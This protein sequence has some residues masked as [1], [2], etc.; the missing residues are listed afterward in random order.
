LAFGHRGVSSHR[1]LVGT[2]ESDAAVA[3]LLVDL[4]GARYTTSTD[5]D[6]PIRDHSASLPRAVAPIVPALD[7]GEKSR[8]RP[9]TT[10][11]RL[12]TPTAAA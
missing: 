8:E 2:D 4:R 11:S 6:P 7:A 1:L 9:V 5:V 10:G 3:V 12:A